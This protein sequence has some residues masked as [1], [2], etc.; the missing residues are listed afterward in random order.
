M[1][2]RVVFVHPAIRP[3][4]AHI[5]KALQENFTVKFYL[6][7]FEV[8]NQYWSEYFQIG[9]C[10]IFKEYH[11]F[12]YKSGVNFRLLRRALTEDYDVWIGSTLYG[13]T[14]HFAYPIV[15][16]RRRKFVLWSEDW[17]WGGDLLSRLVTPLCKWIL[18]GSDLIIVAGNKQKEFACQ[19][20]ALEDR[21]KIAYNSYIPMASR[22]IRSEQISGFLYKKKRFRILYLGRILEY[23]G[24]D[25]LIEAYSPIEERYPETTELVVVG[26][27]PFE[28]RCR[29]LVKK[30]GLKNVAFLGRMDPEEVHEVY[31]RADVFVHPC[32]WRTNERVRGESWGFVINEAMS[33]GLPVVTTSAVGS[34]YD[35]IENGKSGFVIPPGDSASLTQILAALYTDDSLRRAIGEAAKTRIQSL[36]TPERQAAAFVEA[37]KTLL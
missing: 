20:G 8:V 19:S 9:N 11:G 35:L 24:L 16:A 31:H 27:G 32:K 1:K 36:F 17:Y 29:E 2:G 15:K 23:K 37:V 33:L 21:I 26:T 6:I 22:P 28:L 4:R 12:G 18:R 10:E 3:Y 5:Y 30:L 25:T 7:G 13:F 14:T 34:A